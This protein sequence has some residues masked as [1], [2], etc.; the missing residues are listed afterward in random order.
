MREKEKPQLLYQKL[1]HTIVNPVN[2]DTAGRCL[3]MGDE[4]VRS[5]SIIAPSRVCCTMENQETEMRRSARAGP[6]FVVKSSVKV[7]S[8]PFSVWGS[9]VSTPSASSSI[10]A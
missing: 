7:A 10:S 2:D 9:A 1:G 8:S 3:S 6:P 4:R 5:A